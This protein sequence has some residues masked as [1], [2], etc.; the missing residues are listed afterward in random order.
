MLIDCKRA[1]Q[2][3]LNKVD[4]TVKSSIAK[5]SKRGRER[6]FFKEVFW[7]TLDSFVPSKLFD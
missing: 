1:V 6:P 2:K 4:Q 3:K 5:K 7:G